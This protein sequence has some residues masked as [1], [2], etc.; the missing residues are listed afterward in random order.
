M[1]V[2]FQWNQ[3]KDRILSG[4]IGGDRTQLFYASEARRLMDPYVPSLNQK[5][6]SNVSVYV[7]KGV[8][9]VHYLSPYARFQYHGY[10]MVSRITGSPWARKGERKVLTSRRLRHSTFRHPL[11]TAEWDKAMLA[12]RKQDLVDALQRKV[13]GK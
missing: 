13:D 10:L 2:K 12:A 9:Y 6:N 11:A 8:G 1:Q 5:L 3:S 7:E 4:A